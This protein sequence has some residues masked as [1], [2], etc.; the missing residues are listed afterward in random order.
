MRPPG[1]FREMRGICIGEENCADFLSSPFFGHLVQYIFVVE[2]GEN[3][4]FFLVERILIPYE[5]YECRIPLAHVDGN[6]QSEIL[7]LHKLTSTLVI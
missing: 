2:K 5:G 3:D 1:C 4:R 7:P 6:Q